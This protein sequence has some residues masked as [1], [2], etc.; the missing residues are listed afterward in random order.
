[1]QDILDFGLHGYYLSRISGLWAG[2]KIVTNVADGDHLGMRGSETLEDLVKVKSLPVRRVAPWGAAVLNAADPLVADM[3]QLCR[4]TVILFA[5]DAADPRL[6]QHRARGGRA[7]FTRGGRMWLAEGPQER[8]LLEVASLP[9]THGGR[10]GFQVDNM[11][12]SA[13]A[14]WFLGLEDSVLRMALATFHSDTG[15]VPARFNL[16]EHAG[17]TIILDYGHNAAALRALVEAVGSI[18][19]ER[20][21]VVYTA[22]G[23]RRDEDIIEQARILGDAFD[24]IVVYE[25]QCTRGREPGVIIELMKQGLALGTRLKLTHHASGEMAAI[26]LALDNLR[27]KD[28]L[29]CQIDQ[30]DLGLEFVNKWLAA[31][32]ASAVAVGAK[33]A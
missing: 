5:R 11:L 13:A 16:I 14:G 32:G 18:E 19:H 21:V 26:Q 25:D 22:A 28:L 10:I 2:L 31:H 30:V 8:P 20:R 15:T 6:V 9:I 29:L 27:A 3:A 33:S 17:A 24:E 7:V 1:V 4:G 12:A 23:D